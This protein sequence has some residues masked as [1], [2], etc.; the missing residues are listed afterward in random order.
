MISV[1]IPHPHLQCPKAVNNHSPTSPPSPYIIQ[2]PMGAL[3]C[4]CVHKCTWESPAYALSLCMFS[5]V[6]A[7]MHAFVCIRMWASVSVCACTLCEF[8][9]ACALSWSFSLCW[10]NRGAWLGH[11]GVIMTIFIFYF[12]CFR[13]VLQ[14]LNTWLGLRSLE[15][16]I[17][18]AQ[19]WR[20]L[21]TEYSHYTLLDS[22]EKRKRK[23]NYIQTFLVHCKW[24]YS[25]QTQGSVTD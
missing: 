8:L 23:K 18:M 22:K 4:M 5:C 20:H 14:L 25:N 19:L 24:F 13:A 21:L 11:W 1:Y 3:V 6:R 10:H 15:I 9:S 12:I 2:Y 16:F 17:A 7:K